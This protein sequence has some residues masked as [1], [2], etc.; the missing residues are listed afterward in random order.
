MS[1][2]LT[3]PPPEPTVRLEPPPATPAA[4]PTPPPALAVPPIPILT[5]RPSFSS[6]SSLVPPMMVQSAEDLASIPA[7]AEFRDATGKVRVK[8]YDVT[9]DAAYQ[10]VP[11]GAQYFEGG[12][13]KRKPEAGALSVKA[14]TLYNAAVTAEGK[15]KALEFVYGPGT[16]QEDRGEFYVMTPNGERLSPKATKQGMG[17]RIV[18]GVASEALPTLGA[19]LGGAGGT[20]VGGV[21]GGIAGA[22]AGAATGDLA[23]QGILRAS[24]VESLSAGD[25]AKRA[26]IAGG[27]AA[28][29]QGV[30]VAAPLLKPALQAGGRIAGQAVPK[31]LGWAAG[32]NPEGV[33]AAQQINREGGRAA[34]G[35]WAPEAPF[36]RYLSRI[37][38]GM[39]YDPIAKAAAPWFAN[40]SDAL[41]DAIGVPAAERSIIGQTAA[42]SL[43]PA[44]EAAVKNAARIIKGQID[45][46]QNRVLGDRAYREALAK[47]TA[48]TEQ[49]EIA[50]KQV[51]LIQE[52]ADAD[53][54]VQA[55]LDDGW[56]AIQKEIDA[57]PATASGDTMRAYAERL[58]ELNRAFKA[59]AKSMYDAADAAAGD[60]LPNTE[61]LAPWAN[62]MLEG[63]LPAARIH[64]P[65]EVAL[66]GAMAQGDAQPITSTIVDQFGQPI[67]K[68]GADEAPKVTFG[69]LHDLRNWLRYQIDWNDLAAGP[70]QG[71]FKVLER[72]I[73]DTLHDAEGAP[74]LKEAAQLLD[75]ADAFYRTNI[76]QFEDAAV[77]GIMKS[78]EAA[79]PENA[80]AL[81][82]MVFDADNIERVKMFKGMMPPDL[83]QRVVSADLARMVRASATPTGE[84]NINTFGKQVLERARSGVLGEAYPERVATLV[85]RQSDRLLRHAGQIN[86]R[87]DASDSVV[88]L[89][90]KADRAVASAEAMAARDPLA[91]LKVEMGK[92]QEQT[93]AAIKAGNADIAA[94]PLRTLLTLPAEAAAE[95][96]ITN[97]D[98]LRAAAK[99]FGPQEMALLRQAWARRTLQAVADRIA[100]PLGAERGQVANYE[101]MWR[102]MSEDV[103]DILFPGVTKDQMTKM[104]RQLLMMFPEREGDN[105]AVGMAG[106]SLLFHP[107]HAPF[108]P[109]GAQTILRATPHFI[110]RP[111]VLMALSKVSDIASSPRL[112]D[113]IAKGLSGTE[114]ERRAAREALRSVMQG[115]SRTMGG[116]GAAAGA[117]GGEIMQQPGEGVVRHEQMPSPSWRQ[118][119]T[120]PGMGVAPG[121]WR[122]RV[123]D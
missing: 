3:Q 26:A 32:V 123:T 13:L 117:E 78:G 6:T 94:N 118:R 8:P 59:T 50:G 21:P 29:G 18:A 106:M 80:T 119:I 93:D 101:R 58:Q 96:I 91:V 109:H 67:V 11:V 75:R 14:Q 103:Q 105:V 62:A 66:L 60:E 16:V 85:Q 107:E 115:P 87:A 71:V 24:G 56:K 43:V 65:R 40:R 116:I 82:K 53:A 90:D 70:R 25:A 19:V 47:E 37:S 79:N 61:H 112:V 31:W 97:P 81:A 86:V 44:G 36:L 30:G 39:G 121:S 120:E 92:I 102:N 114:A 7:G 55:A 41:L 57:A 72:Q 88:S 10:D 54:K 64:Y 4:A 27:S 46:L 1:A 20:L 100:P 23:N 74:A 51:S 99:D 83:W 98:L 73:N 110:G 12:E 122:D 9:D 42:P 77:K 45:R 108:L 52:A 63:L 48:T 113:F 34:I 28:F 22:A 35:A 17:R 15:R 68:P 104:M 76:R 38:R 33:A 5:V 84:V 89:M 111:L 95:K 2:A 69:A 49:R